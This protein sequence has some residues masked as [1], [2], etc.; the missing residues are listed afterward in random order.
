MYRITSPREDKEFIRLS[1]RSPDASLRELNQSWSNGEGTH[2][3]GRYSRSTI[4]RRLL[5]V[6]LDSHQATNAPFFE[7]NIPP[8]AFRM[9]FR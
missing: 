8:K 9:V 2:K 6:G 5:A 3:A 4:S 1:R 7:R